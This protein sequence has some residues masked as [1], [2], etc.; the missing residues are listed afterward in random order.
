[1]RYFGYLLPYASVLVKPDDS[2]RLNGVSFRRVPGPVDHG[3]STQWSC[4]GLGVQGTWKPVC[5]PVRRDLLRG[6]GGVINWDCRIPCAWT[7]LQVGDRE[8]A[9]LGYGEVLT[10]SMRPWRLP[11]RKLRWGHFLSEENS[12][13]WIQWQGHMSR[14]WVFH[15]GQEQLGATVGQDRV[16]MPEIGTLEFDRGEVLRDAPISL[17]TFGALSKILQW[18]P[19]LGRA[20]ETKWLGRGQLNGKGCT[21][22]RWVI[23]E[24]VRW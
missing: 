12:T 11:F 16:V 18:I 13:V 4:E 5:R 23:H 14:S 7:T 1:M 19:W 8:L 21:D 9:G 6:K 10:M 17:T 20:H 2:A 22:T 3:S 24:E 15:N